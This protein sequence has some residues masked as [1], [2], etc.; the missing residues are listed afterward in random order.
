MNILLIGG[1]GYIGSKFYQLYKNIYNI[2]SIDMGMFHSNLGYSVDINYNK[3]TDINQ[4]DAII[5]LAGHSSVRMC[6]VPHTL[7]QVSRSGRARHD[8]SRM[9]S[10]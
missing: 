6:E 7:Q 9:A 5:C 10:L 8:G 2:T 4:Y 3:L 1:N